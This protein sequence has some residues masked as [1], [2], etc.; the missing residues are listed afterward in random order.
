MRDIITVNHTSIII[1]N[2]ELGDCE[3]LEQQ[4]SVW[5]KICYRFNPIGFYYIED[6]KELRV[7]RG[8]DI[9]YIERKLPNKPIEFTFTPDEYDKVV[10]TLKTMPKS[11]IQRKSIAFL[12]GEENFQYT[13]KF[14]QQSLNLD[15]GDGKTYCVIAS[16]TFLK[17]KSLIVTHTESIKQQWSESLLKF[18]SISEP[19]ICNLSGTGLIEKLV[20]TIKNGNSVP[21]KVYLV[22]HATIRNY[23]KK[24]GWDAVTE[25]F[26]LLKIGVKVF[27]E[28]HLEFENLVRIDLFTNTKKTFY[29]TANFERSGVS[30]NIVFEK[31]F[32]RIA[33]YGVETKQEKRK[34][35][36][37][38]GVLYNT[39][40][41]LTEQAAVKNIHGFDKNKYCDYTIKQ[42]KFFDVVHTVLD[43]CMKNEG[44]VLILLSKI[45]ACEIMYKDIK[46]YLNEIKSDYTVSIYNSSIPEKDK[47]VALERDIIISTQKSLGT[48]NDIKG[49]RSVIMTEQYSSK[50]IANQTAGRLREYS[51]DE[52]T[53][54]IELVDIGFVR[55]YDMYKKRIPIFKKKCVQLGEYKYD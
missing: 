26:K 24:Y 35:I 18:T 29:L 16:L 51:S 50:I 45:N 8:L 31:C 22:N 27:D 42:D 20:K 28:A 15:T 6:R 48:G 4:L 49:L 3:D 47:L 52:Y 32:K 44:K 17:M 2:Y 46:E 39:R 43:I 54:Y 33:K 12:L 38:L 19:H 23:A 14:S 30:E 40:P 37:Y 21:Y 1:P 53:F 10:F 7:P 55:A 5:D 36:K 25:L 11:D 41:T 34:H 13:K 9:S